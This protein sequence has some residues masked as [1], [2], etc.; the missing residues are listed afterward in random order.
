MHKKN[1]SSVPAFWMLG[2]VGVG[3]LAGCGSVAERKQANHDFEYL[4]AKLVTKPF[5]IPAGLQTP[6]YGSEY[7]IP[8][9][10]AAVSNGPVGDAVDVRSPV[11]I[12]NLVPGSRAET[13]GNNVTL[14]FTARSVTQNVD[15]EVWNQLVG[16]LTRRGIVVANLDP[17]ARTLDTDWFYATARLTPWS[18]AAKENDETQVHQRYR[19]QLK[20]DPALHRTGLT[21]ELLSHE[22]YIDGDKDESPLTIFERR[23]YSGLMLNQVAVDYDKQLR[24]GQVQVVNG[25]AA[26]S[27][28]VDDNGLTA[29]LVDAPFEATWQRL[30]TMLPK[31]NFEITSKTQSKGLIVVDYDEPDSDFWKA[32]DIEPFGLDSG[33]YRLQLGEFKGKTSITLFDED[34]KPVPTSVVSKMFIGLSKAFGR[35]QAVSTK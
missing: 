35:E 8:P 33:T 18:E 17:V 24:I 5:Q 20:T 1:H 13:S 26:M 30:I 6:P 29:W 10:A 31:L 3:L 7:K 15:N 4:D 32:H 19:F 11:Q 14:W 21:A 23:R 2:L 12:L 25:R 16:F 34:K 22:A 27:L 28:G 9:L